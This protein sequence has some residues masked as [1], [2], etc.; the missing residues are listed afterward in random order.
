MFTSVLLTTTLGKKTCFYPHFT[1][2]VTEAQRDELACPGSH[3]QEVGAGIPDQA[4]PTPKNGLFLLRGRP[5]S[6]QNVKV[7]SRCHG[8]QLGWPSEDS[9]TSPLSPQPGL[10][11]S[12]SSLCSLSPAELPLPVQVSISMPPSPGNHPGFPRLGLLLS[13]PTA[14]FG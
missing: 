7:A 9:P 12:L 5:G 8:K 1:K 6:R 4:C 10:A 11:L 2:K 13:A 14:P 3:S